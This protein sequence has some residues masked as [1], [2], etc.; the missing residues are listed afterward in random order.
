MSTGSDHRVTE[1][2][3][4]TEEELAAAAKREAK[5][6]ADR[7]RIAAKRKTQR[8]EEVAAGLASLAAPINVFAA[9]RARKRVRVSGTLDLTPSESVHSMG[10]TVVRDI[11][12][13]KHF[14]GIKVFRDLLEPMDGLFGKGLFPVTRGSYARSAAASNRRSIQ[15]LPVE[16][17]PTTEQAP[18]MEG[19]VSR[20]QQV[21]TED[22]HI[23][24]PQHELG[25]MTL[26]LSMP[27]ACQQDYHCDFPWN[28]RVFSRKSLEKK[29]KKKG[30]VP[31]PVSVL[32]AF[33]DKGASLPR[34]RAETIV[35]DQFS[36]VVFRGDLEHAGAEWT[37]HQRGW[38]FR[39][40]MY[41]V[42]AGK[43]VSAWKTCKVPRG[44]RTS[45]GGNNIQ[46]CPT[47]PRRARD[48]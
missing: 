9:E 46:V 40:H 1:G 13:K 12:L 31:Y 25:A 14:P 37:R 33:H 18:W 29:G 42:T 19:M 23:L 47:R 5:L 24:G 43:S 34:M 20:V 27:G 39:V 36:A 6:R 28:H 41:F 22:L 16:K 10:A 48:E 4:G 38:N 17:G 32:I 8:D 2:P 21:L 26:L 15:L 44:G 7:E 3:G 35:F 30:T 45:R 11:V